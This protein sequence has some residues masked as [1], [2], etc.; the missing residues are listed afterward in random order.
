MPRFAAPTRPGSSDVLSFEVRRNIATLVAAKG[1]S[2]NKSGTVPIFVPRKWGCPLPKWGSYSS[3]AHNAY[4]TTADV[5]DETAR[6][7][8]RSGDNRRTPTIALYSPFAFIACRN[9][10]ISWISVCNSGICDWAKASI[11]GEGGG[12]AFSIAWN[13]LSALAGIS[14][15]TPNSLSLPNLECADAWSCSLGYDR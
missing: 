11:C 13:A 7:P 14:R 10:S 9:C 1:R 15:E 5:I 8:A 4:R 12:L 2:R 3:V 6:I